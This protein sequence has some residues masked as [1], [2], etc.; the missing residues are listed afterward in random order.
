M[1]LYSRNTMADSEGSFGRVFWV[2]NAATP[3][4]LQLWSCS[5]FVLL[6]VLYMYT[7]GWFHYSIWKEK[8]S[9]SKES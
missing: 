6:S 2:T 3:L 4:K 5:T 7:F 9:R 8:L 1:L